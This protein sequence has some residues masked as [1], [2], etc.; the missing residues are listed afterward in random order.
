M[1][2]VVFSK[3]DS[4]LYTAQNY[5]DPCD[6]SKANNVSENLNL[7]W[8]SGQLM[9]L[10]DMRLSNHERF[11][12][13]A[14]AAVEAWDQHWQI[15]APLLLYRAS[16]FSRGRAGDSRREVYRLWYRQLREDRRHLKPTP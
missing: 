7:R 8:N 5:V 16:R 15:N 1:A 12:Y 13:V 2:G 11:L 6:F 14:T 9:N 3:D 10:K 4:L